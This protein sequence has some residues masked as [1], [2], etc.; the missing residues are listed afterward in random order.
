MENGH[1]NTCHKGGTLLSEPALPWWGIPLALWLCDTPSYRSL[2]PCWNIFQANWIKLN[3]II[4]PKGPGSK[5]K[6][7]VKSPTSQQD[8]SENSGTPKSSILIGFSIINHPF[9]GTPIFGNT[10]MNLPPTKQL[11]SFF[12]HFW[13]CKEASACP[14][15]HWWVRNH[16]RVWRRWTNDMGEY[17]SPY[18]ILVFHAVSTPK[19]GCQLL[20]T[21]QN[22]NFWKF[23]PISGK[24]D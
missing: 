5:H 8:V 14:P 16:C 6:E 3:W 20:A 11:R 15:D 17:Q 24:K 22:C 13:L 23:T 21:S 19:S 9:W 18:F 4:S 10:H 7:S 1:S 2:Q 12:G